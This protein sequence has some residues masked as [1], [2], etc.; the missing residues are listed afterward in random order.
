MR[1]Y[2]SV[3]TAVTGIYS[4]IV[5]E[6]QARDASGTFDITRKR[7]KI[8]ELEYSLKTDMGKKVMSYSMQPYG[9][10]TDMKKS[11]GILVKVAKESPPPQYLNFAAH[12][13]NT[14]ETKEFDIS[15][16]F[17]NCSLDMYPDSQAVRLAAFLIGS[18]Q[19]VLEKNIDAIGRTQN[20]S[21]PKGMKSEHV[22]ETFYG[23]HGFV[24]VRYYA[25]IGSDRKIS[26]DRLRVKAEARF[27]SARI[28]D[29]LLRTFGNENWE[30][31]DMF[32]ENETNEPKFIVSFSDGPK[33]IFRR[34]TSSHLS[35]IPRIVCSN[36]MGGRNSISYPR[37][38][39]IFD[40]ILAEYEPLIEKK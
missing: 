1:E 35:A 32:S 11:L 23:K 5:G 6:L 30:C 19:T 12:N 10:K 37:D 39:E 3:S 24:N 20:A 33:A 40:R 2:N 4:E 9:P 17:Y 34:C 25:G 15:S 27:G 38:L 29:E 18:D 31:R 21:M 16:D 14:A 7:E 13:L 8:A 26:P 36:P 28:A 22:F